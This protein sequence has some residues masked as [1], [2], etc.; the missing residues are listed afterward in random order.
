MSEVIPYFP[1]LYSFTSIATIFT[2]VMQF[3]KWVATVDETDKINS[4]LIFIELGKGEMFF[5]KCRAK[6]TVWSDIDSLLLF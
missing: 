3:V 6:V 2:T 5:R 4:D 1:F